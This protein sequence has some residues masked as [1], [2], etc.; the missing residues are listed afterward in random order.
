MHPLVYRPNRASPWT[1]HLL[2]AAAKGFVQLDQGQKFITL[3]LREAQLSTEE[4]SVGEQSIEQR[5][6]SSLISQMG[7]ARGILQG[8]DK[9]FL[10]SANFSNPAILDQRVRY[11][12]KC[13]LNSLLILSERVLAFCLLE[14][15]VRLQ[16]TGRKDWLRNLRNEGPRSTR[17][18]KQ[19]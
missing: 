7:Q 17:T 10:L 16:P 9:Q 3:R 1:V 15:D 5:V 8:T 13:S 11:L 14:V 6:Y 12:P 19:I 18:A 2:P 4:G